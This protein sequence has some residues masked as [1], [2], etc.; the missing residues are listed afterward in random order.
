MTSQLETGRN[1]SQRL[2][3]GLND[4]E[5]PQMRE[6]QRFLYESS[7]MLREGAM[8]ETDF[9]R[10][11]LRHPYRRP[12]EFTVRWV[13][14]FFESEAN[15]ILERTKNRKLRITSSQEDFSTFSIPSFQ[16]TIGLS[17]EGRM[18][19]EKVDALHEDERGRVRA[20][21]KGGENFLV[22]D[23]IADVAGAGVSGTNT[24]TTTRTD[25][26]ELLKQ[27]LFQ[28]SPHFPILV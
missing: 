10:G 8:S 20:F 4:A 14:A 13:P 6:F 26:G 7:E 12:I 18:E 25:Q 21:G 5:A 1:V 28:I 3:D 16:A 11:L 17:S 23:V 22:S 2:Y 27:A 15:Y 9:F 19:V 24:G